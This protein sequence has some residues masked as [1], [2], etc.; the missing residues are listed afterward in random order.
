MMTTGI[1]SDALVE[2]E[3]YGVRYSGE[4]PE[5]AFHSAIYHLTCDDEGPRL[6]LSARQHRYLVDAVKQRYTDIV[7]RD[8]L[9]AN[10]NTS[11][12]RGVRR[13]LINWK[14]FVLFCVRYQLDEG[15]CRRVVA[16]T[17]SE[18]LAYELRQYCRE[19]SSGRLN[20][21]WAELLEYADLIGMEIEHLPEG[22]QRLCTDPEEPSSSS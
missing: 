1:D 14:R 20:C 11:A 6:E 18:L 21:S 16:E 3:W 9:P 4:I 15:P 22:S 7:L 8:L 2:D 12:Y 19:A 17:L 13:S 10:K 5:V